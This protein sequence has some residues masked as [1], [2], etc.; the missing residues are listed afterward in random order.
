MQPV[1][2]ESIPHVRVAI[3]GTGFGGLGTAAQLRQKGIED[4]VLFERADE[5]GGVWRENRYP[6]AACDVESRL[7]EFSFAPNPD[8]SHRFGRQPEIWAY[9]RRCADDFGIR[10]RIRFHHN[11]DRAAWDEAEQRWAITTSQGPYTA[12]VLVAAPGSL[13]EPRLPDLPGL[14]AFD[15][16]AFHSS[17]WPDDLDLAGRRVAVIGTGASAIQIVPEIQKT[18]ERVTVYQRTPP[19]LIPRLDRPLGP[20]TKAALR[21]F[22]L[23]GRLVRGALY[24]HHEVLGLAFRHPRVARGAEALARFHLRRQV[25]DG[26]L[27]ERLTPKYLLGCKR[28]ILSDDYYPALQEANVELVGGGA[29]EIRPHGVVGNDGTEH[30]ADVLVLCTGFHVT[31]PP[32]ARWITGRDGHTLSD[33]W[34]PSMKAHV[35]TTVYGFPNLFVLQGPNT[36]LGHSSVVLIAEAQVEHILN[37]LKY[38][39]AHGIS[40]IEPRAEAQAQFV[41]EVDER[42]QNTVWIAGGCDSWY[43]DATGRNSTLWPRSTGAFRRRVSPFRAEDYHLYRPSLAPNRSPAEVHA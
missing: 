4:F 19:W 21:R 13:I 35:G 7:Y 14:D 11:V 26:A 6:G 37:A 25:K 40:A 12:D 16:P 9:L 32:F 15:G 18:A 5:V 27:R 38:M 41:D 8:W 34:K 22:P 43:L 23:L 36:G 31:E 2:P 17:R 29:R 28:I 30:P 42:M 1:A 33:V 39:D 24:L 20:R 10:D 3:V